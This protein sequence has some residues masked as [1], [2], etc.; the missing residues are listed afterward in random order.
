MNE[1]VMNVI[2]HF[3]KLDTV[4]VVIRRSGMRIVSRRQS[5][6][7][8]PTKWK[9]ELAM[10]S[11][12]KMIEDVQKFFH[13]KNGGTLALSCV[14]MDEYEANEVNVPE[15]LLRREVVVWRK[16]IVIPKA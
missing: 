14:D 2:K 13:S 9:D 10:P 8:P 15:E 6:S 16:Q 5:G 12:K 11:M 1:H 7:T 3:P 4:N